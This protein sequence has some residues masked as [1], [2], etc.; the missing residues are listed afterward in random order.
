MIKTLRDNNSGGIAIRKAKKDRFITDLKYFL[1]ECDNLE[2]HR[3]RKIVETDDVDDGIP[4]FL[5]MQL[6][7][8]PITSVLKE[9]IPART[10]TGAAVEASVAVAAAV[11]AAGAAAVS[12]VA[13]TEDVDDW[14]GLG[15]IDY[16]DD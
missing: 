11:A 15:E 10:V 1:S 8:L 13:T 5:E 4:T 7:T 9:Y 14:L 6:F 12:V 2:A 3:K 16:A